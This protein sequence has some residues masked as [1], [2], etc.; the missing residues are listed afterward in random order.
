MS[1]H[2]DPI[3]L[4]L[5]GESVKIVESY[6]IREGIISQP[7][8]FSI[9]LGHGGVTRELLAKAPPNT[10]FRIYVGPAPIQYGFTDGFS[11]G[12]GG[13]ATQVTYKG[14]DLAARVIDAFIESELSFAADKTYRELLQ[15]ALKAVG[16]PDVLIDSSNEANRKAHVGRTVVQNAPT[17]TEVTLDDG[18]QQQQV[19]PGTKRTVYQ[20]IK[21]RL[22]TRWGEF[23][24]THFDRA[25]LFYWAD[26]SGGMVLSAPNP[27]QDPVARIVRRRGITNAPV[28]VLRHSFT[29]D[30][31][32]R[33]TKCVVYG[34][35]GGR[36]FGRTKNRGEWVDR[37]MAD[38]LGGENVKPLHVHDTNVRTPK[39]A[40]A[41]AR[42]KIA[43]ANR[44][45]WQLNYTLAGHT[46]PSL[47]G[48]GDSRATWT[49]DTMIE[50]DDEELGI[51]GL[52][53]AEQCTHK[54][55]PQTESTVHLM[56][57]EDLIFA[58]PE[59]GDE[60]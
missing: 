56:R 13:G 43:E 16:L 6:E 31:S 60:S 39:Q 29:N 17:V 38:L 2:D 8:S 21:A 20:T 15:A 35:G 33:Y 1:L 19:V 37:E 41:L 30:I 58:D 59:S 48:G 40:E 53:Y 23:L 11:T 10:P 51:R 49:P 55:S 22:G 36:N 52:L 44:N 34:R 47:R 50:V 4:E 24:K 27:N 42:R 14:R 7:G 9:R 25:G 46:A 28:N 5:G 54:R 45:G 12:D 26:C 18:T 57:P 3:T 32:R